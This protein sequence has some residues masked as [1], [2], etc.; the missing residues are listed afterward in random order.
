MIPV[1]ALVGLVSAALLMAFIYGPWQWYQ[2]DVARQ[3]L[4][5]KRDALFDMAQAGELD[6]ASPHYQVLRQSINAQIRFAHLASWPRLA[7]FW[8]FAG[9][10]L[11]VKRENHVR[12]A[13]SKIK[14]DEAR[15]K[16][17]RLLAEASVAMLKMMF[18]KSVGLLAI[19]AILYIPGAVVIAA[20]SAVG[21]FLF[22]CRQ[23]LKAI[24]SAMIQIEA[25]RVSI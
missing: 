7:V 11:D 14:N 24:G 12:A 10:H 15:K 25:D 4:F 3:T 5:E 21:E 1:E 6:F 20:F 16:V 23:A 22:G 18:F 9:R 17:E 13:I 2:T 19:F 8:F